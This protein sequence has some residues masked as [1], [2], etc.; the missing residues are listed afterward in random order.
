MMGPV[1]AWAL[2]VVVPVK[3]GWSRWMGW[4]NLYTLPWLARGE[5]VL[6]D[7]HQYAI[8]SY[9]CL[10]VSFSVYDYVYSRDL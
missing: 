8:S 10:S 9:P 7:M 1:A 6:V 2:L 4:Y 5:E 3:P